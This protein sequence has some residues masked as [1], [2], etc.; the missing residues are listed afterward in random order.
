MNGHVLADPLAGLGVIQPAH[1]PSN[2]SLAVEHGLRR[3]NLKLGRL[4]LLPRSF[5]SGEVSM[6]ALVL[7]DR[8]NLERIV[9]GFLHRC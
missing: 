2:E 3:F 1:G 4:K 6:A 9:I 8:F 5:A 7:S